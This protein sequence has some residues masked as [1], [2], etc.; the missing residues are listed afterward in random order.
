MPKLSKAPLVEVIFELRWQ[1]P[2]K[3]KDD[4]MRW[5]REDSFLVAD[6]RDQARSAGYAHVETLDAPPT[7]VPHV[8]SHRFRP[9]PDTWPCYQIGLGIL[10]ANLTNEFYD[11][12]VFKECVLNGLRMLS[13]SKPGGFNA[14]SEAGVS[15]KYIDGFLLDEG[16]TAL[17]FI[18]RNLRVTLDRPEDL[19]ATEGITKKAERIDLSLV[20]SLSEPAGTVIYSLKSG[21][22]NGQDALVATTTLRS[23]GES[24]PKEDIDAFAEWLDKAHRVQKEFF[25][26]TIEKTYLESFE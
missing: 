20:F 15:L 7:F 23:V 10:T 13:Q 19:L 14:L 16:K 8:V 25:E 5:A 1:C 24:A 18:Q 22:V 11:W 21:K 26:K 4:P 9:S 3:C 2:P 6:F 12:K 17:S